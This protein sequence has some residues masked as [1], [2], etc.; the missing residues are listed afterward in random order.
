[1]SI[2]GP[3]AA[4]AVIDD[5]DDDDDRRRG[6]GV[7]CP[8]PPVRPVPARRTP[9]VVVLSRRTPLVVVDVADR[10]RRRRHEGVWGVVVRV[11]E[12]EGPRDCTHSSGSDSTRGGRWGEKEWR[13]VGGITWQT[14]SGWG[15]RR[16]RRRRATVYDGYG[17]KGRGVEGEMEGGVE[18]EEGEEVCWAVLVIVISIILSNNTYITS[19]LLLE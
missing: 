2:V 15:R 18:G 16:R 10:G 4:A 17:Y 5:D 7:S 14:L 11:V 8:P 6:G 12:E 3:R 1:M 19:I 13:D 9:L